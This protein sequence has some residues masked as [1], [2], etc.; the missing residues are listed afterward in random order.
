MA[1][2]TVKAGL[3]SKLA[4]L[5]RC[6]TEESDFLVAQLLFLIPDPMFGAVKPREDGT[7]D[8]SPL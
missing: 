6:G 8:G 1:E 7:D 3:S 2:D 5:G 4:D